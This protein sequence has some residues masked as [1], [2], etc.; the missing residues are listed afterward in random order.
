M[1]KLPRTNL[2]FILLSIFARALRPRTTESAAKVLEVMILN[3]LPV[4]IMV[5]GVPRRKNTLYSLKDTCKGLYIGEVQGA[6]SM[7]QVGVI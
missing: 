1:I 5:T 7:K 3:L 4:D 6:P 2:T